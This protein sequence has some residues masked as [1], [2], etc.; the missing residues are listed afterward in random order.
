MHF[1]LMAI[2]CINDILWLEVTS[3]ISQ[4]KLGWQLVSALMKKALNCQITKYLR[5]C[6]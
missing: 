2:L 3:E 4:R 6:R 5:V 1:D